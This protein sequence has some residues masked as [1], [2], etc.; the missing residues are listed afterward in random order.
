VDNPVDQFVEIA[1]DSP[2]Q[3]N[4]KPSIATIEYVLL[5]SK[6][7]IYTLAELKFATWTQHGLGAAAVAVVA[8]LLGGSFARQMVALF[9]G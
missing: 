3:K 4:G 1:P 7:N 6:P 8:H 2:K 5:S 9:C